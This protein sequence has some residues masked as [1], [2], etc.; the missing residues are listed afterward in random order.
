MADTMDSKSIAVRR[1][2]STPSWG[3][4]FM[5]LTTDYHKI[6]TVKRTYNFYSWGLAKKALAEFKR[7]RRH[8]DVG[9]VAVDLQENDDKTYTIIVEYV[10]VR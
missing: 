9:S 2:G 4:S 8:K 3:T 10:I 1:E 5:K 6:Q 7:H